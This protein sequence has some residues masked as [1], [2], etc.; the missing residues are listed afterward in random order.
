MRA[1]DGIKSRR[2]V[3]GRKPVG[4]R[5]A[6]LLTG[7]SKTEEART[8]I[9]M[10]QGGL[11]FGERSKEKERAADG[12]PRLGI[13]IFPA[14]GKRSGG[15]DFPYSEPL[16]AGSRSQGRRRFVPEVS[17]GVRRNRGL[18]GRSGL[19]RSPFRPPIR[20]SFLTAPSSSANRHQPR[21]FT[22]PAPSPERPLDGGRPVMENLD[23]SSRGHLV[24]PV[25]A[26]RTE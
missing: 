7:N 4:M 15:P 16:V 18:L 3:S 17:P 23:G 1:G 24:G 14:G 10:K 21:P 25:R 12:S 9:C 19:F 5:L 8:Q 20:R 11:Y 6:W 22:K 26:G 2:T 13:G